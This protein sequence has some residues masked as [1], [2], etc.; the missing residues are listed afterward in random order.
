MGRG[1]EETCGSMEATVFWSLHEIVFGY[2]I[3]E[4]K[5]VLQRLS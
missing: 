2:S 3:H 5:E 4:S 1:L